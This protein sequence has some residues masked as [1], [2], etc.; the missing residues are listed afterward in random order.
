MKTKQ[1]LIPI[2]VLL[3]FTVFAQTKSLR[4]LLLEADNV[5][6]TEKI[7]HSFFD[8]EKLIALTDHTKKNFLDSVKIISFLKKG[9]AK[10]KI[11]KLYIKI[12]IGNAFFET[13][14][15]PELVP[16]FD[17][18]SNP[19]YKTILFTKTHK[20][21]TEVLYYKEIDERNIQKVK[22]FIKWIEETKKLKNDSEKCKAY[23]NKYFSMI[24]NNSIST[25]FEIFENILLPTSSFMLYY[26]SKAPEA[27]IL[28]EKQKEILKNEVFSSYL[29]SIENTKLVYSFFPEETLAFYIKKLNNVNTYSD[30]FYENKR[31]YF[32][33]L[34]FVLQE[35]NHFNKDS[36][37]LM[38]ILSSYVLDEHYLQADIFEKLVEKINE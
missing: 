13:I 22:D 10:I 33:F 17:P 24:A 7:E 14:Q 16:D 34:E 36:K 12:D 32:S 21:F 35:T 2:L 38:N 11:E 31:Y 15:I 30:D 4:E 1:L 19:V 9:K 3:N 20:E 28:N 27:T 37:L 26:K 6:I 8:N 5:A 29:K 25:E 23:L 18:Y